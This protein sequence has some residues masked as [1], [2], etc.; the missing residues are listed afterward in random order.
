MMFWKKNTPPFETAKKAD[1]PLNQFITDT[2]LLEL[3]GEFAVSS[4][5]GPGRGKNSFSQLIVGLVIASGS[6]LPV[7]FNVLAGNTSDASTLPDVYQGVDKIADDGP[8]ELLMDRIYPA[9]SNILFLQEKE[10][11]RMVYWVSPLK[12]DLSVRRVRAKIDQAYEEDLWQ[13][14]QY[15]SQKESKA[16]IDPPM[17]AYETTWVLSEKIKPDLKPGQNRRPRGSIKTRG[18]EVRCVF[19]QRRGF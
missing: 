11:E 12:T 6:K 3:D 19:Y 18:I 8:I 2:T 4:K 9:P 13:P 1:I 5:V 17:Q 14:I 16:R 15:R 7:G 10:T